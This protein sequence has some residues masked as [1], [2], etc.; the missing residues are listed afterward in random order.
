MKTIQRSIG[1][2]LS[3][4][5]TA[6]FAVETPSDFTDADQV[7]ASIEHMRSACAAAGADGCVSEC[8]TAERLVGSHLAKSTVI[9][10]A[11]ENNWKICSEAYAESLQAAPAA[12][13]Y[14]KFVIDGF[15]LLGDL[16]AQRGRF[17]TLEAR[18]W[19]ADLNTEGTHRL[20]FNGADEPDAVEPD[21]VLFYNGIV[22]DTG[23]TQVEATGDGRIYRIRHVDKGEPAADARAQIIARW[24]EPHADD[25]YIM[26]WGCQISNIEG[27]ISVEI[28]PHQIEYLAID[29]SI[30]PGWGEIYDRQRR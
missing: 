24:G 21:P 4:A 17:D 19:L 13:D 30:R 27:C 18:G 10:V 26:Q 9:P 16:R 28:M 8:D 25:G 15:T 29:E 22:T 20:R 14:D 3:L 5:V 23:H 2:V 1:A 7:M 12:I 6:A 11:V